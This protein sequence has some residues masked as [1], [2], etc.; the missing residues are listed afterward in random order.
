MTQAL[1]VFPFGSAF[2]QIIQGFFADKWGRKV[3]TIIMSATSVVSFVLFYVG[4]NQ[5]WNAYVVG[6]FAGA[7]VGSYWAAG[8]IMG[9]MVTE[10]TPTSLRS[11][12]MAVQPMVSGFIF[13]IFMAAFMV[14]MNVLGDSKIGPL[15]VA[16]CVPTM[17]IG[18]LIMWAKV[19][20]TKGIDL[21]DVRGDEF[22]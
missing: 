20:E 2:F 19:K 6:F 15:C 7:A 16:F 1:L 9:M 10:S 14:L 3:A 21:G 8:D 11:S 22:E 13:S 17:T 5:A 18:L 12:V 4:A